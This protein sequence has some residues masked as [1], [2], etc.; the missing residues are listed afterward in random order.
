[1]GSS[2]HPRGGE[3]NAALTGEVVRI[4][5]ANIGR[6]PKKSSTFHHGNIVVTVMQEAMTKA[7]QSLA[8]NG[9]GD[10][11]LATRRLFQ[12][13]MGEELTR[14]VEELT[15]HNVIA[16]MSD[17]HLDPDMAVEIFILDEPLT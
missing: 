17:Y 6:G 9:N 7:E 12:G 2:E 5:T 16:F 1:M 8:R 3:L 10:A 13:A 4:H 11:V 15:G 14:S